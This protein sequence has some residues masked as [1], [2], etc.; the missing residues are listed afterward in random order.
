MTS[1]AHVRVL[2]D[3]LGA[4]AAPMPAINIGDSFAQAANQALN[5]QL[6]PA[7]DPYAND[8]F[9]KCVR[10]ANSTRALQCTRALL[11][12]FPLSVPILAMLCPSCAATR[13]T[14]WR[15]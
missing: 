5:Q 12:P 7:F 15:T 6:Q 1:L 10:A 14:C 4:A 2:R 9:F 13:C 8:L 3:I 11:A